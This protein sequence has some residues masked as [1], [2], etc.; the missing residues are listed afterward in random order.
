[1]LDGALLELTELVELVV[2]TRVIV[3]LVLLSCLRVSNCIRLVV[4]DHHGVGEAEVPS[5][6]KDKLLSS[7]ESAIIIFLVC[8][9]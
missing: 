3:A 5:C 7:R 4:V 8:A 2:D 6:R 9:Q 1:M